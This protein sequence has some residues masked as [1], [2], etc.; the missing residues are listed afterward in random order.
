[1]VA[2]CAGSRAGFRLPVF[3]LRDIHLAQFPRHRA[4]LTAADHVAVNLN[5]GH[6]K[7]GRTG[8]ESAIPGS[9][10]LNIPDPQLYSPSAMGSRAKPK[11][12]EPGVR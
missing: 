1:M 5:D 9:G 12:Q 2:S 3:S 6:D 4:R 7:T 11:P 8:Q 10:A